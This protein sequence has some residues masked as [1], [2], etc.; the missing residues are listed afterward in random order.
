VESSDELDLKLTHEE[1]GP[2]LVVHVAGEVDTMTSP[3]LDAYVR[4]A[5]AAT[6]KPHLVLDLAA[7]TF[8]GSSGLSV[9]IELLRGTEAA[10]L[11]LV[12]VRGN[13]PVHR[14]L[15]ALGLTSMFDVDD[16]VDSLL[17]RL[18]T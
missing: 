13:R 10:D 6:P 8:L 7:V 11:H 18:Q 2:A 1:V 9:L 3:D 15:D 12:G 14:A 17:G 4:A 5:R 16:S